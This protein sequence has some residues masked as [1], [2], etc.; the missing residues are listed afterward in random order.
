MLKMGLVNSSTFTI[1]NPNDIKNLGLREGIY[2]GRN[3][4]RYSS[5]LFMVRS[6]GLYICVYIYIADYVF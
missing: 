6:E 5:I 1:P 2:E 4:D 3:G